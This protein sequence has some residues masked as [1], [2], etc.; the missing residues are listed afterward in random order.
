M[1]VGHFAA[2]LAAKRI[3]PSISTGTL[4]LACMLADLLWCFFMLAGIEHVEFK[5]GMG[6][7]NYIGASEIALSHSLLMDLLWAGSLTAVFFLARRNRRA[8]WVIFGAVLSHWLLDWISHPPD[9]PL[10][11][12]MH[13]YFGLGLWR[14]VPATILVEGGFWLIAVVLYARAAPAKKR[15]GVW[16]YWIGIGILTLAWYNNI[17][18]PPPRDP[19]TAPLASF[20]FF[21]LAVAWA[22]WMNR[23]RLW[24]ASR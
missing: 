5:P 15:S 19:H 23:L 2:G 4:V 1:L 14:S 6:A 9:M 17:A 8:A 7:A 3:A 11:P 20:C 13:R 10:T 24:P 16:A 22:Y 12:G 21:S 18:G